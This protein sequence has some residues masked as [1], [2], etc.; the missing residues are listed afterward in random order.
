MGNPIPEMNDTQ[1]K[2]ALLAVLGRIAAALEAQHAEEETI[3]M[4]L[5]DYKTYDWPSI[6]A[7]P[8]TTDEDGVAQVWHEGKVY[9]RRTNDK[10]GQDIWFSRCVGKNE[11]GTPRYH[12]LIEFKPLKPAEPIGRKTEQ[13]LRAAQPSSAQ[14]VAQPVAQQPAAQAPAEH[15]LPPTVPTTPP[16]QPGQDAQGEPLAAITARN[17]HE[18]LIRQCKMLRLFSV[19]QVNTAKPDWTLEM[20]EQANNRLQVQIDDAKAKAA[21][22]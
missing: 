16:A 12:K 20:Y 1:F 2:I 9:T 4:P 17:V 8:V 11:D 21:A 14:P 19:V 6:G 18:S 15:H 10:F 13:T 3:T 7:K 5:G 22:K